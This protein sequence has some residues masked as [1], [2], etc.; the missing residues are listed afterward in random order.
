MF[1]ICAESFHTREIISVVFILNKCVSFNK[2]LRIEL[3]RISTAPIVEKNGG[4]NDPPA[5]NNYLL[6]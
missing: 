5:E 2:I 3:T 1:V 4:S 6:A